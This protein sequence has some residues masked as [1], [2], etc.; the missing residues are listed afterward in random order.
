MQN[1]RIKFIGTGISGTSG[2]RSDQS[3]D[4]HKTEQSNSLILDGREILIAIEDILGTAYIL[5]KRST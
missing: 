2:S 4:T 1:P 3:L 5:S